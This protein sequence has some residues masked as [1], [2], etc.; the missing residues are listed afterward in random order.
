MKKAHLP[1]N[2]IP[3]L[4]QGQVGCYVQDFKLSVV[5]LGGTGLVDNG[6]HS[7]DETEPVMME[8]KPV[9]LQ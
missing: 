4:T 7:D 6:N 9:M 5:A 3:N 1:G 8:T 2:H